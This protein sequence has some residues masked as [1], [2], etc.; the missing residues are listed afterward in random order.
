MAF[1]G[2]LLQRFK[3]GATQPTADFRFRMK[4]VADH[5]EP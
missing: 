2:K 5:A 4:L 1:D 3:F